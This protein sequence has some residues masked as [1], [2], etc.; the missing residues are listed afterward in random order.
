MFA[1]D[2]PPPAPVSQ[3]PDLSW[4][5]GVLPTAKPGR[6]GSRRAEN[7][8]RRTHSLCASALELFLSRGVNSVTIDEIAS[9]ANVAKGSFYRYYADKTQL[10]EGLLQPVS[11]AIFAVL[12]DANA[13]LRGTG[14]NADSART[15]LVQASQRVF[16]I[17]FAYADISLLYLQERRLPAT[18][19]NAPIRQLCT[20]LDARLSVISEA[21]EA[22]G[23]IGAGTGT[24][25][26]RLVVG[27]TEETLFHAL[28]E[29]ADPDVV[30][31]S[32]LMMF[33]R[34][35]PA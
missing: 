8:Q 35:A 14:A 33:R 24:N 15:V 3:Y 1:S 2:A 13:A 31:A 23:L 4:A 11:R 6:A 10:V 32:F 25:M 19:A 30:V 28:R 9:G 21:A 29:Q 16:E 27:A 17:A 22:C 5:P 7:R 20:E 34:S 12:D 18:G 26:R